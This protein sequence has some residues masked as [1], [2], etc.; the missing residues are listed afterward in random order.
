M[1]PPPGE[2]EI[3]NPKAWLLK[4]GPVVQGVARLLGAGAV[5]TAVVDPSISSCFKDM[6][7]VSRAI[8]RAIGAR[9]PLPDPTVAGESTWDPRQPALAT[10]G[11][12]KR[13]HQL[14]I[15]KLGPPDGLSGAPGLGLEGTKP[16]RSTHFKKCAD[17][18]LDMAGRCATRQPGGLGGNPFVATFA[19]AVLGLEPGGNKGVVEGHD[20][21][22][23]TVEVQRLHGWP[24]R[25]SGT[26]LGPFRCNTLIT[27]PMFGTGY[28]LSLLLLVLLVLILFPP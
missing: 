22:S 9:K 8:S 19:G 26:N 25:H 16:P 7:D 24:D 4:A 5:L 14:L 15:K 13:L 3:E 17:W 6:A 27:P 21:G 10:E 1:T 20:Q 11:S 18:S 23:T 12:L 28:P 2:F